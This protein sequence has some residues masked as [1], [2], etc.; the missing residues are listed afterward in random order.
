M[1]SSTWP[2]VIR[3]RCSLVNDPVPTGDRSAPERGDRRSDAA[4]DD[5]SGQEM[6]CGSV[7]RETGMPFTPSCH[8]RPLSTAV[9]SLVDRSR[10]PCRDRRWPRRPADRHGPLRR[11]RARD[12]RRPVRT[13]DRGGSNALSITSSRRENRS[14]RTCSRRAASLD[15][16]STY[17]M[18]IGSHDS[19]D[20]SSWQ[21]TQPC[22][23]CVGTISERRAS[24]R[25]HDSPRAA[26]IDSVNRITTVAEQTAYRMRVV[27]MWLSAR[28]CA[29]TTFTA[30]ESVVK[31]QRAERL[32]HPKCQ[33]A[34]EM[35]GLDCRGR[36][37]RTDVR[38]CASGV[39]RTRSSDV[40]LVEHESCSTGGSNLRHVESGALDIESDSERAEDRSC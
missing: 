38:T 4:G 39:N 16:S 8:K 5:G 15:Q 28:S 1:S 24:I 32:A 2:G 3:S 9:Q 19:L 30:P 23:R 14:D 34:H 25:R 29:D 12:C 11:N 10:L 37:P 31:P 7:R 21:L 20:S 35:S 18:R 13:A 36:P 6:P 27:E 22:S 17:E 40:S 26:V 33:R